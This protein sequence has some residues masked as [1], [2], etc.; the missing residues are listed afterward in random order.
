MT[1]QTLELGSGHTLRFAD[2]DPDIRLNTSLKD[3]ADQLPARVCAIV[4][5]RKSDG[6]FCEGAI[7][8]DVPLARIHFSS[9]KSFWMV[10]CWD[11]LTLSPSLLCHCGDHGFIKNGIWVIA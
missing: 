5:H 11:P 10:D 1:S 6:A 2:W 9:H 7:F 3:I 8:F 4:T